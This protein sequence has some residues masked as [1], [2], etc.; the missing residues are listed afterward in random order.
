MKRVIVFGATGTVGAYTALRLKEDGI[1]V[2]GTG[3]RF[4][5]GGFFAANGIEYVSMD[6]TQA[7]QFLQKLPSSGIDAIVNLAGMLPARMQGY[8][9]QAYIDINMSGMLNILE[10]AAKTGVSRL[11]YSQSISDVD[12]LMGTTVPVPEDSASSFPRDNDHSVYSI[13][14]NAAADLLRHYSAHFGFEHFILR[15]PNIYLYHPNPWYF[16]NGEKRIQGYRAMIYKAM[17]GEDLT[18]WGNPS[19]VRDMVYVKDCTKLISLCLS[20]ENAPSGV[21]NAGTGIG[22]SLEEQIR[23]IAE[24]FSPKDHPSRVLYA[25]EKPDAPQYIFDISKGRKYLGYSPSYSYL[26]YLRDFRKE[27]EANRFEALWGPEIIPQ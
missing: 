5:D 19:R 8:F 3:S 23:G 26:D 1:E 14:K 6:I 18:V 7:G 12:Y 15:F 4:T 13:T 16:V 2:I 27:M 24:V 10:Y 11:V 25:P 22:T 17:K 20:A 9:P 21:Y